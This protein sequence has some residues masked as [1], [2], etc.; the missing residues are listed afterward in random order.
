MGVQFSTIKKIK[1]FKQSK[2]ISFFIQL[3][4]IHLIVYEFI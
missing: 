1:Q 3:N 4:I 2:N